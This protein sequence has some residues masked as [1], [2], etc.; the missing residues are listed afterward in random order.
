[1]LAFLGLLSA[2][3]TSFRDP[4]S[5][6]HSLCLLLAP[7]LAAGLALVAVAATCRRNRGKP[8][9]K[10]PL[11][12]GGHFLLGHI[13]L[14][15][16]PGRTR[17]T[18]QFVLCVMV[19]CLRFDHAVFAMC[20]DYLRAALQLAELGPVVRLRILHNVRTSTKG[21]P[22]DF[23]L[24]TTHVILRS[25]IIILPAAVQ[26]REVAVLTHT[27]CAGYCWKL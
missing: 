23:R 9:K 16:R 19:K 26:H 10:A 22:R 1:M 4:D 25:L 13:P 8:R 12:P 3:F 7:A 18:E 6:C 20:V 11:A 17:V 21:S 2:L 14:L 24:C 5:L 15:A 27:T